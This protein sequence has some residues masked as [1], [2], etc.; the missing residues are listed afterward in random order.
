MSGGLEVLVPRDA[1]AITPSDTA[2]VRLVGLYVGGG[3]N[4]ALQTERG[5]TPTLSAVP[6]G[7][8][9]WLRIARVLA[10]GTTATLM[11]GLRE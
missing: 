11:V 3:G 8:T 4:V 5:G 10:T 1:V 9:I 2:F 6:A 7:Q